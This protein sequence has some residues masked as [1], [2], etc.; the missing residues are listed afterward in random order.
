MFEILPTK[1]Y[2]KNKLLKNLWEINNNERI[3][4]LKLKREEIKIE[5]IENEKEKER[6]LIIL[7]YDKELEKKNIYLK[8]KMEEFE[9]AL[10]LKKLEY[11]RE[12]EEKEINKSNTL[13]FFK[14]KK[15]LEEEIIILKS[16]KERAISAINKEKKFVEISINKEI[17]QLKKN[18]EEIIIKGIEN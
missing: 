12:I 16:E 2:F 4:E 5:G 14:K 17:S 13:S 3:S 9:Y 10:E 15:Y 1:G 7:K 11:N 6:L 18:K 8:K